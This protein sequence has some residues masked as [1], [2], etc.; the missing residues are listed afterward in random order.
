MAAAVQLLQ[1]PDVRLVTLT[2]PGGVGKTRLAIEAARELA[3][4]FAAGVR[5]VPLASLGSPELVLPAIARTLGIGESHQG[6]FLRDLTEQLASTELLLVLDNSEHVLAAGT[7]LVPLLAGCPALK[8]LVTSRAALHVSGEHELAV[9]PLSLPVERGTWTFDQIAASEAVR[10]FVERAGAVQNGFRLTPANASDVAEICRRLDGLPL[11]IELAAARV[12]VFPPRALLARLERRLP[13]L[14]GGPR[15]APARLRTMRDAIAWSHDLLD[16]GEQRLFRRLAVFVGGFTLDAAIEVGGDGSLSEEAVFEGI[17]SLV[18]QSLLQPAG[19]DDAVN[20]DPAN[21][22]SEC[23]KPSASLRSTSWRAPAR[24]TPFAGPMQRTFGRWPNTPSPSCAAPSQGAWIERLEME[25]PNLRA[26]L[27]WSL[28]AGD[29]ETGLRLAGALYWFWFMRNHV[30]EGREWFERARAAG[31]EPAIAAGK[32]ALGAGLLGWR[33]GEFERSKV[34]CEEALERFTACNDRWGMAIVAHQLAHL[35]EDMDHDGARG[36]AFLVDSVAQFES[37]GDAWGVAF[38]RRCLG[39]SW[40]AVDHDYERAT[41]L[42]TP[43][44]ASLSTTG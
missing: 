5:F 2:G 28:A 12:K 33:V 25:L 13:F 27:D 17:S 14:T 16:A 23:S 36:R 1:Q 3:A 42:L 26:V 44:L 6:E 35:A 40:W 31:R 9:P 37:I 4:G 11:A 39:W 41:S 7:D 30:A 38:S 34:Y 19:T 22:D 8:L 10:L 18:D 24:K 43:A 29:V 32:A 15:D 20:D 21:R